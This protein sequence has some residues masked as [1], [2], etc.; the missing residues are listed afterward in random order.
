[1]WMELVRQWRI[2]RPP[3]GKELGER[4][5]IIANRLAAIAQQ[6]CERYLPAGHRIGN[7]WVIG[8]VRNDPGGSMW[9]RLVASADGSKRAG[10]WMD[11]AGGK[12]H[13]DLLDVIRIS[14]RLK[15]FPDV[16]G[17]AE[18]FLGTARTLS[19]PE[20]PRPDRPAKER[21]QRLFALCSSIDGSLAASYLAGRSIVLPKSQHELRYHPTCYFRQPDTDQLRAGPAMVAGVTNLAGEVTGVHRTFLDPRGYSD[22]TLGKARMVEPRLSLGDLE[23]HGTRF[24]IVDDFMV[25]A[26][27]IENVLS[28]LTGVPRCPAVSALSSGNLRGLVLP[29]TL[30]RLYIAVDDDKGGREA[31][32]ILGQRAAGVGI[33]VIN[34]MPRRNDW[35]SDLRLDGLAGVIAALKAMMLPDDFARAA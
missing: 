33:S 20:F 5:S 4:A 28:V 10:K 6:V 19:E 14:T 18:R 11:A 3:G 21:A 29:I 26:E 27:G 32:A 34:L 2:D 8:N 1:M 25:A 22:E 12:D 30:R 9:V 24:G 15:Y 35:N 23:G 13:G 31:G 17:E 7:Y 16:L